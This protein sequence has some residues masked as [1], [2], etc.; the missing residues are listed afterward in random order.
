MFQNFSKIIQRRPPRLFQFFSKRKQALFKIVSNFSK[1]KTEGGSEIVLKFSQKNK[2]EGD[3]EIVSEKSNN[4]TEKAFEIVS[5]FSKK[6]KKFPEVGSKF[7]KNKTEKP[8]N[9]FKFLRI[10]EIISNF[11]QNK[12]P[13]ALTL[14]QILSKIRYSGLPKLLFKKKIRDSE[15]VSKFSENKTLGA[16]E[17]CFKFC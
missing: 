5:N 6:K 7:S 11:F 8:R 13:K 12:T 17:I 10:H 3:P 15:I 14:L 2:P 4:N 1:S 9:C 16:P